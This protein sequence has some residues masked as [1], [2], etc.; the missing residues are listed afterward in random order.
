MNA[1]YLNESLSVAGPAQSEFL[2]HFCSRPPGTGVSPQLDPAI[3]ALPPK[4]RLSNILWEG[5]LRGSEPYGVT[6]RISCRVMIVP[7]TP[8]RGGRFLRSADESMVKRLD[9]VNDQEC[10]TA[11]LSTAHSALQPVP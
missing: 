9:R 10:I 11:I 5:A 8:R 1:S 4:Q 7:W 6:N 3:A 2:T